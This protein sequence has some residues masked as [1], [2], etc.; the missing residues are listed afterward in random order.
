MAVAR[1]RS[2]NQVVTTRLLIGYAGASRAPTAM[3]RTNNAMKLPAK[4]SMTVAIDHS[5]SAAV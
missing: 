4:P 1:S 2:G 5:S 3:R